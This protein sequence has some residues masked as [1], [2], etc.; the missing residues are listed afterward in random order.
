MPTHRISGFWTDP[1]SRHPDDTRRRSFQQVLAT[2][3]RC[4]GP[5]AEHGNFYFC[6]VRSRLPGRAHIPEVRIR[7]RLCFGQQSH[8]GIPGAQA[9][10]LCNINARADRNVIRLWLGRSLT[11][12]FFFAAAALPSYCRSI[13]TSPSFPMLKFT[14]LDP[15]AL[16]LIP[17]VLRLCA[18]YLRLYPLWRPT[19]VS[20]ASASAHTF[21]RST[22]C[23]AQAIPNSDVT[24]LYQDLGGIDGRGASDRN[25]FSCR[26]DGT[27]G[28]THCADI[29]GGGMPVC[30]CRGGWRSDA[31]P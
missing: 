4:P 17:L 2:P 19:S 5:D 15:S 20:T 6:S 14:P 3:R 8:P 18:Q 7:D 30:R 22:R 21:V 31:Q 29:T 10:H 27:A 28:G 26:H 11:Y 9:A 12:L 24:R 23:G 25:P 16:S 13:R 1:A